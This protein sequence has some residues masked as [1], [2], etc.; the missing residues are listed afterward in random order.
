MV[1]TFIFG[2]IYIYIYIYTLYIL[3]IYIKG[4]ITLKS[5][6]P[7]RMLMI[8]GRDRALVILVSLELR[9]EPDT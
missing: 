3:Y 8:L 4:V 7:N 9:M 1:L 5:V 6:T 2:V